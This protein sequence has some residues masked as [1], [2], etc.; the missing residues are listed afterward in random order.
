MIVFCGVSHPP[1]MRE[2]IDALLCGRSNRR[3]D[4]QSRLNPD[5]KFIMRF[6]EERMN[7]WAR[8]MVNCECFAFFKS[9]SLWLSGR[10]HNPFDPLIQVT[11]DWEGSFILDQ[12]TDLMIRFTLPLLFLPI[13]CSARSLYMHYL[14]DDDD[15]RNS[16]YT[17]TK[18]LAVRI[19]DTDLRQLTRV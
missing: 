13:F 2:G 18:I 1:G 6:L 16:E 7:R 8:N 17:S 15:Q 12:T 4:P 19:L 11:Y 3:M 9:H 14:L 5:F 10:N